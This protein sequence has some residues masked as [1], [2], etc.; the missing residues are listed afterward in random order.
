[1]LVIYHTGVVISSFFI[2]IVFSNLF[3][4]GYHDEITAGWESNCAAAVVFRNSDF[5]IKS[6]LRV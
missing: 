2:R 4:W 6:R 3:F 5:L 1:M